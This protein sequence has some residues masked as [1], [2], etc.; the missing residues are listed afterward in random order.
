M[1]TL[2]T[3]LETSKFQQI[4]VSF[5]SVSFSL[6]FTETSEYQSGRLKSSNQRNSNTFLFKTNMEAV[7]NDIENCTLCITATPKYSPHLFNYV[8]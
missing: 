4:V 2:R 3:F 7:E 1:H 6:N 5:K 8:G